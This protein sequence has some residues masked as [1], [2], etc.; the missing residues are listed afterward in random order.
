ML[1]FKSPKVV[2][3]AAGFFFTFNEL[4]RISRLDSFRLLIAHGFTIQHAGIVR[5]KNLQYLES[6]RLWHALSLSLYKS[7]LIFIIPTINKCIFKNNG[8][9]LHMAI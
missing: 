6:E 1:L 8:D 5:S 2:N 3:L 7:T 4:D 9:T